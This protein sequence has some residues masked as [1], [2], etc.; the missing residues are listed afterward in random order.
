MACQ[1]LIVA[2][3]RLYAHLL[4]FKEDYLTETKHLHLTG[5]D[6]NDTFCRK[7]APSPYCAQGRE[8]PEGDWMIA[9]VADVAQSCQCCPK[10]THH[11]FATRV[12]PLLNRVKAREKA[13]ENVHI[14]TK[15]LVWKITLPCSLSGQLDHQA[16]LKNKTSKIVIEEKGNRCVFIFQRY[17]WYWS[18]NSWMTSWQ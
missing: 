14:F 8:L 9:N 1:L 17:Q 11:L 4:S 7:V 6:G 12:H 2:Y 13:G 15:K 16:L 3:M 18:K 10:S 5:D